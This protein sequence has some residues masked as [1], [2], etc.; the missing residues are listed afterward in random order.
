MRSFILPVITAVCFLIAVLPL[1]GEEA[2]SIYDFTVSDINGKEVHLREFSGKVVMIV[3][4]A[5]KCGFT[6]QYEGLQKLYEKYKDGGFVILGFPANNFLWQEPGTNDEI[7]QFCKLNYGVS[8]PMF[9][10]I[11]VA[12]RDIHPLYAFLTS[13]KQNPEFSGKITWNFNKFLVDKE[14]AVIG[15]FS[16]K[17]EP[18]DPEIVTAVENAL[19]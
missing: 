5:S 11:S 9:G 17:T 2:M 10:K 14:G 7:Q 18:L 16:S 6:Y 4:V 19:H 8:F 15:R 12:G 13:K 3:N 1:S